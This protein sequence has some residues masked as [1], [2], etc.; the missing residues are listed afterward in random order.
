MQNHRF[1]AVTTLVAKFFMTHSVYVE[2]I[3]LQLLFI[4]FLSIGVKCSVSVYL[5]SC[6]Q[7]FFNEMTCAPQ[8]RLRPMVLSRDGDYEGSGS[9]SG[10]DETLYWA[11]FAQKTK[12]LNVQAKR[13]V[14]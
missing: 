14:L 12:Q 6:S 13:T 7:F 9:H 3:K 2:H 8:T 4:F 11:N 10:I 1:T 5:L